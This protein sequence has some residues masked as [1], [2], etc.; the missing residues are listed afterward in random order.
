[1]LGKNVL[2]GSLFLGL[3]LGAG[4]ALSEEYPAL[5]SGHGHDPVLDLPSD[6]TYVGLG[7]P[8][9]SSNIPATI[10][11]QASTAPKK[12]TA[13]RSHTHQQKHSNATSDSEVLR[14]QAEVSRLQARV[15][16]LEVALINPPSA[17]AQCEAPRPSRGSAFDPVPEQ[18]TDSIAKRLRVVGTLIRKYGRAYDY[19]THTL[20]EL[21]Q[22]LTQLDS[23]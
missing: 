4:H 19:R 11:P 8:I 23:Q 20:G 14:L 13:T 21:L 18:S 16:E 12:R 22:I 3:L 5:E 1:M 6:Q 7:S 17:P 10:A 9:P 2:Q 15:A